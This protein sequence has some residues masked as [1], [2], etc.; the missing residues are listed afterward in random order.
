MN[1]QENVHAILLA[2]GIGRRLGLD[3]RPKALLE[4]GSTSLLHRH[5]E[6]LSRLGV[7]EV[8]IVIGYEKDKII[9]AVANS[10]SDI[11]VRFIE[12]PRFSE[13][14]IVSLWA[15]RNVLENSDTILLMDADVI[16]DHRLLRCILDSRHQNVLLLDRNI[17]PGDEPVK[18]C[19]R[20][21]EIVDFAKR[22]TSDCDFF[23]ESVGFF[24]LSA[25]IS[26]ALS[27][28]LSKL[29]A[30]G[31]TGLEYEEPIRQ[32]IQEADPEVFRFED[33][34]GLPWTEID[35]PDDVT[36]A[37]DIFSQIEM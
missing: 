2:A 27:Q 5:L 34:T 20:D 24:R 32:L 3:G 11:Q 19:V 35:F 26:K 9:A 25:D 7:P 31:G 37:Q 23:G 30:T 13:G 22:P 21:G 15:A 28:R 4:I 33:I 14:S 1:I 6:I 17:E 18:I 12:N 36:K 10:P 29:L 16:Y 8:T